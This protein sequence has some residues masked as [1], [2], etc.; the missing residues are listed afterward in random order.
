MYVFMYMDYYSLHKTTKINRLYEFSEYIYLRLGNIE[1][2]L[3]LN[4]TVSLIS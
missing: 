4:A 3:A 2:R 1:F